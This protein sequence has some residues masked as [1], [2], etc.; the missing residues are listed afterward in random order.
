MSNSRPNL[1]QSS[2]YRAPETP[3]YL[4]DNSEPYSE[5]ETTPYTSAAN[6]EHRAEITYQFPEV[7]DEEKVKAIVEEF[8]N[9][10]GL[11]EP[12]P[13]KAEPDAERMLAECMGS[14]FK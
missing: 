6:S 2:S 14:L 12:P 11:M 7:S 5:A 1:P 8:G 3:E 4:T 13:G 10:A 9:I